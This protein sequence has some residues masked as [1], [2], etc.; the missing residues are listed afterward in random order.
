MLNKDVTQRPTASQ[1]LGQNWFE[2]AVTPSK[3]TRN[4]NEWATVGITK[5]FLARPSVGGEQANSAVKALHEL[6]R[7]LSRGEGAK[8]YGRSS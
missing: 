6:Q 3:K 4:R 8:V 5:S 7:S 1:V 2:S